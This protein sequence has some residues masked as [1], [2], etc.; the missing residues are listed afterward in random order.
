MNFKQEIMNHEL[1]DSNEEYIMKNGT[2]PIILTAV[3]TM[4]Q[5]KKNRIKKSEPF[6]KAIAKY[7]AE[8]VNCSYYIKLKDNKI[9]SNSLETDEFK[10][11]LLDYIV[12]N[13]IKLLIDIHGADC[14]RDFDVE[15]GTLNNLSAAYSTIKELGEAFIE[16]GIKNIRFNDPFKGGGIT[17][18]IYANTDIDIIQIEIN[19]KYRD[20]NNSDNIEKICQSLINFINQYN[21]R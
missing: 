20:Y 11:N 6:T 18:F 1:S 14:N 2:I 8:Q 15:I 10:N 21:N 3:H 5:H 17:Q 4:Q 16:T 12:G 19:R 9:D 13:N 7:V